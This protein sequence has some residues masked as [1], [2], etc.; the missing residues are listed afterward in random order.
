[1]SKHKR[2]GLMPSLSDCVDPSF[3][4]IVTYSTGLN[5]NR[6][7]ALVRVATMSGRSQMTLMLSFSF[8]PAR[9]GLNTHKTKAGGM[10]SEMRHDC[11]ERE[12]CI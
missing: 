8:I 6:R 2:A 11:Q 3:V 7:D 4:S 1:M 5:R 9:Q 10:G 12:L